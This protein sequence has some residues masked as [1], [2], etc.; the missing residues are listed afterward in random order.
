MFANA[1]VCGVTGVRRRAQKW[2]LLVGGK[3]LHRLARLKELHKSFPRSEHPS[4]LGD[5]NERQGTGG[6][7]V[8]VGRLKPW[9]V[10]VKAPDAAGGYCVFHKTNSTMLLIESDE[11][12]E[13]VCR[14]MK[15]SGCEILEE[16]PPGNTKASAS[17]T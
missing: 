2:D 16:M 11:I 13:A 15:E 6:T 14:K 9:L 17:P 1:S 5:S 8:S 3:L 7:R 10:L 12:K 4:T